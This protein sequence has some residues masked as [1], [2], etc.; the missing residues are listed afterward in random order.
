MKVWTFESIAPKAASVDAVGGGEDSEGKW[1]TGIC[2]C[3]SNFGMCCW[4]TWCQPCTT[5]QVYGLSG[6]SKKSAQQRCNISALVL[7]LMFVLGAI[8]S[9]NANL[10]LALEL[11]SILT[12]IYFV[13]EARRK[14]RKQAKIEENDVLDFVLAACCTSCSICQLFS[15]KNVEACTSDPEATNYK[16]PCQVLHDEK[17]KKSAV[18]DVDIA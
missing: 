9:S 15:Q 10:A 16:S 14:I 7:S 1:K 5:A 6:D 8:F 2:G 17:N 12:M 18:V 13:F 11:L 3:F 4:V